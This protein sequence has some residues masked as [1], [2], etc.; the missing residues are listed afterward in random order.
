MLFCPYCLRRQEA[1]DK[2]T[3]FSDVAGFQLTDDPNKRKM[4]LKVHSDGCGRVFIAILDI[5]KGECIAC[6][7]LPQEEWVRSIFRR[8]HF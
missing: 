1:S 7:K 5:K 8:S 3:G 4:L 2:E 6:F